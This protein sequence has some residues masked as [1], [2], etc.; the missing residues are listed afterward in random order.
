MYDFTLDITQI[1]DEMEKSICI[2][3]KLNLQLYR[4]IILNF[5][6]N[7]FLKLKIALFVKVIYSFSLKCFNKA[8]D[9]LQTYIS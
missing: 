7:A 4:A 9:S 3:I 5:V 2:N 1:I 8:L 6:L